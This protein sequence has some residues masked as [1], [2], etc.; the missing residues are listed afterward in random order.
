M[1]ERFREVSEKALERCGATIDDVD[2]MVTLTQQ[3][4]FPGKILEV[5]GRPEIPNP[6]EYSAGL[7]HF[8]GG[9]NYILLDMARKDRKI[10][11]GDLILNVGLGGV[12]WFASLIRY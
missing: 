11:K 12:A 1:F 3:Y 9:D 7:G 6:K 8:S 5:L 4:S 10:K 2:Y